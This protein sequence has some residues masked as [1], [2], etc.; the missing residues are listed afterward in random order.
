M[1]SDYFLKQFSKKFNKTIKGFSLDTQKKLV[2]HKWP[3]NVREL[4]NAIERAVL[5]EDD[6]MIIN[7]PLSSD[8][9]ILGPTHPIK[10][11][12]ITLDQLEKEFII[13]TLKETRGHQLK[14]AEKLKIS[15]AKLIHRIKKYNIDIKTLKNVEI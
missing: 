2:D 8:D 11:G 3:G 15:R 4:K 14:A 6:D 13:N 1:L 9:F 12:G 7:I 10:A 5:F